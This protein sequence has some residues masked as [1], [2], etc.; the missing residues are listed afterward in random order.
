VAHVR[1]QST[2][3]TA[4][5][6][7]DLDILD[8]ETAAICGVAVKTV[9]RWRL[10]YQRQG[11]PRGQKHTTVRCPRCDDVPLDASAYAHLLGWYLGDGHIV[12]ARRGVYL[13]TVVNDA[14]YLENSR[15]VADSM[16]RVKPAGRVHERMGPGCRITALGWKHWP[17]LFPQHGPG[18]KHE[19]RIVLETWQRDIVERHPDRFLRGLFHSD[20]CRVLNHVTREVAGE[21]K[22]YAYPRYFFSNRSEDILAL[23]EWALDLM[24][25]AHRRSNRWNVSVAR[26]EAVARLDEVVG[27][28]S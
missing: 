14:R 6:L 4:L 9:R 20:G 15:E 25:I 26:R 8:R 13:L 7:S 2:V 28:K 19:R 3:D 18:R 22:R 16:G 17:C 5:L 21:R 1:D 11:L 23:C 24:G 10:R 27:P 12:R